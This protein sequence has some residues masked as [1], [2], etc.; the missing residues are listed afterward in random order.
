MRLATS[1]CLLFS[2]FVLCGLVAG[3]RDAFAQAGTIL[4]WQKHNSIS[5]GTLGLTLHDADEFGD[6]VAW[7]GDLDGAGPSVAALAVSAIGD[8]DGGSHHGA[9][10]ILFINSSGTVLSYQKISST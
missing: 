9:V 6:G 1:R 7:L 3:T 10:Y 4:S 8:D 2:L 5:L